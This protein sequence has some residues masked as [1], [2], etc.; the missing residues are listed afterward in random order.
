MSPYREALTDPETPRNYI[1]PGLAHDGVTFLDHIIRIY[2][3]SDNRRVN[4]LLSDG[5]VDRYFYETPAD[6]HK[7]VQSVVEAKMA[8]DKYKLKCMTPTI[9]YMN[10]PPTKDV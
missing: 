4:Y 10:E 7:N 5:T 2:V 8:W 9:V 6:A 1:V 3:D